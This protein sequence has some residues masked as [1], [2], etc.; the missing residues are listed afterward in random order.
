[1]FVKYDGYF[2]ASTAQWVEFIIPGQ[3]QQLSPQMVFEF[4]TTLA[5]HLHPVFGFVHPV[6]LGKGQEYNAAG[7]LNDKELKEYGP[8]SICARTWLGPWL[9][10]QIGRDLLDHCGA[11]VADTPW[12]G[13]TVD[14]LPDPWTHDIE[15]LAEAR[16]RVMAALAPSG[17]FGDYSVPRKYKPGPKWT[18]LPAPTKPT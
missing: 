13:V 6:W 9:V 3:G 8:Q 16:L 17:V 11:V 2:T 7:V 4:G 1:M 5:D 18:G 10:H 14:L 15:P 12:G